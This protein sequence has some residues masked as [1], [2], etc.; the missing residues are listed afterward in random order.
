MAQLIEKNTTADTVSVR[1]ILVHS[2]LSFSNLELPYQVGSWYWIISTLKRS[3]PF[4]PNLYKYL[5]G[6][7]LLSYVVVIHECYT[8]LLYSHILWSDNESL[9]KD[10]TNLYLIKFYVLIFIIIT[11]GLTW[12]CFNVTYFWGNFGLKGN[13][14]CGEGP[15]RN[16]DS[17]NSNVFRHKDY[18]VR[19]DLISK[20]NNYSV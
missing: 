5:L 17:S 6:I 14:V 8:I 2:V 13:I 19:S 16:I 15:S 1:F 12:T 11:V 10:N 3:L 20:S 4:R 9:E 18:S 7:V